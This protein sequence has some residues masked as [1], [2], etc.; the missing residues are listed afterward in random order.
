MKEILPNFPSGF[1]HLT[2]YLRVLED[3]DPAPGTD[4][5]LLAI[6]PAQRQPIGNHQGGRN[7]G[8]NGVRR[9]LQALGFVDGFDVTDA[10]REFMLAV[11]GSDTE[12]SQ[13]LVSLALRAWAP[14]EE[15]GFARRISHPYLVLLRLIAANPGMNSVRASFAGEAIDDSDA[16]FVRVNALMQFGGGA[17]EPVAPTGQGRGETQIGRTMADV[18]NAAGGNNNR[19]VEPN[20]AANTRVGI[21][22]LGKECGDIT[23]VR[24]HGDHFRTRRLLLANQTVDE[25]P[26]TTPVEQRPRRLR[27]RANPRNCTPDDI[28]NI[29]DFNE[30]DE[31]DDGD[32]QTAEDRRLRRQRLLDRTRRHHAIVQRW[33]SHTEANGYLTHSEMPYDELSINAVRSA[34]LTEVK[35]LNGIPADQ[36]KQVRLAHGQLGYYEQFDVPRCGHQVG[37]ITRIALFEDEITAEHITFLEA[38]GHV[39]V[40]ERDEGDFTGPPNSRNHADVGALLSA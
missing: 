21:L 12:E 9:I 37:P 6:L 5:A 40:W 16:E 34:L 27:R 17:L 39:V 18:I 36:V 30:H 29:Q 28:A 1:A 32:I 4:A 13:R 11:E 19:Q 31:H 20:K 2:A 24:L 23:E 25:V 10:G 38:Q 33:C 22:R 35:T 15:D 3:A 14:P 7:A 26:A 8:V